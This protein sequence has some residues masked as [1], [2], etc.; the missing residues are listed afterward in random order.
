MQERSQPAGQPAPVK[1]PFFTSDTHF[2]HINLYGKGHR[3]LPLPGL[4]SK[5]AKELCQIGDQLI[6]DNWNAVVGK[7]DHVYHLGDFAWHNPWHYIGQLNGNI[8]LIL[9]NHD[10]INAAEASAFASVSDMK[11]VSVE[12]QKIVLCHYAM[13]VW[14]QSGR[15]RWHLYGHSHGSLFDDPFS[16][17]FDVGM[18]CWNFKPLS[19][20]EVAAKMA[21]KTFKPYDHHGADAFIHQVNKIAVSNE[22]NTPAQEKQEAGIEDEGV[23]QAP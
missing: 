16:K 20:A 17:S 6:I 11:T 22:T 7:G 4:E 2:G 14:N 21:T 15:G 9:G 1:G 13:R 3:T 5:N 23:R 12:G 10:R 18:D 19:F 8:H